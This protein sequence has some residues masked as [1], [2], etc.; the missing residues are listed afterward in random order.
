MNDVTF[1]FSLHFG[2]NNK[3]TENFSFNFKLRKPFKNFCCW[4]SFTDRSCT[5]RYSF[6]T[7]CTRLKLLYLLGSNI[8]NNYWMCVTYLT[9]VNR[10]VFLKYLCSPPVRLYMISWNSSFSTSHLDILCLKMKFGYISQFISTFCAE[11]FYTS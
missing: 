10:D 3:K 2:N 6:V 11:S 1:N 5:F 9:L 7:T 4:C 8:R